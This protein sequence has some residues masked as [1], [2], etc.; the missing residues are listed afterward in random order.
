[1]KLF[2][3]DFNDNAM[4]NSIAKAKTLLGD[5]YERQYRT[6]RLGDGYVLFP[7][8]RFNKVFDEHLSKQ[9]NLSMTNI[10]MSRSKAMSLPQVREGNFMLDAEMYLLIRFEI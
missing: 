7:I 5:A 8:S 2:E 10:V 4:V 1:M 3:S 6:V 9:L